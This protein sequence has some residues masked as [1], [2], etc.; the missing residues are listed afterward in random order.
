MGQHAPSGWRTHGPTRVSHCG[1]IELGVA[2]RAQIP[3]GSR[4]AEAEQITETA[5][6]AASGQKFVED[7]IFAHG[8]GETAEAHADPVRV[9]RLCAQGVAVMQEQI[10]I[11]RRRP[12]TR[13][14]AEICAEALPDRLGEH[15]DPFIDEEPAIMC[16]GQAESAQL[17][18]GQ[19]MEGHECGQCSHRG[20]V[21]AKRG[22]HDREIDRQ[23]DV[24]VR[25]T[26]GDPG[27]RVDEDDLAGLED[28]KDLSQRTEVVRS[29][30]S[31]R[32]EGR[33][34]V[35]AGDLSERGVSLFGP[36]AYSRNGV[37]QGVLHAA[38]G[39]GAHPGRAGI[40]AQEDLGAEPE[41]VDH[42]RWQSGDQAFKPWPERRGTVIVEHAGSFEDDE[43]RIGR[44]QQGGEA[45]D[46]SPFNWPARRV[47][48]AAEDAQTLAGTSDRAQTPAVVA[49]VVVE[50]VV[51]E[52]DEHGVGRSCEPRPCSGDKVS[53]HGKEHLLA[54]RDGIVTNG[55]SPGATTPLPTAARFA[56]HI[57][58]GQLLAALLG[59]AEVPG[60]GALT[61]A[62]CIEVAKSARP[63]WSDRYG[64]LAGNAPADTV[65]PPPALA[66]L[67]APTIGARR[68]PGEAVGARADTRSRVL[69]AA[70]AQRG[71]VVVHHRATAPT[72]WWVDGAAWGAC[73]AVVRPRHLDRPLP[74]V[75]A[76][77]GPQRWPG[78]DGSLEERQLERPLP[79][80]KTRGWFDA[81]SKT[82]TPAWWGALLHARHA[83]E[84]QLVPRNDGGEITLIEWDQQVLAP[85]QT[86]DR[87]AVDVHRARATNT[88]GDG[89]VN[90]PPTPAGLAEPAVSAACAP[91]EA[92]ETRVHPPRGEPV[93]A[94]AQSARPVVVGRT[95]LSTWGLTPDPWLAVETEQPATIGLRL[96]AAGLAHGQWAHTGGARS[97]SCPALA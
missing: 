14:M 80:A 50:V 18:R 47:L 8:L 82:C 21:R 55:R 10:R 2:E 39:S 30:R 59:G 74:T 97:G 58:E 19:S 60:S 71:A 36:A 88:V 85:T 96:L 1:W 89:G 51:E 22:T 38:T 87:I 73:I 31:Q 79:R 23:W 84:E 27:G 90:A 44:Q 37:A 93:T 94:G 40:A 65:V 9:D 15:D 53:W 67:T 42:R 56:A 6:V 24:L 72:R 91:G 28:P 64:A 41:L 25:C 16:I 78:H 11:G 33:Q 95:A 66:A 17:G 29:G 49:G 83:G 3:L 69:V 5:D 61:P 77:A 46:L 20:I 13:A 86:T 92:V 63:S 76:Q 35:V 4:N 48:K 62:C 26:D 7:P 57:G 43:Y 52:G 54:V 68:T 70:G 75:P 81:W 34:D 45:H 32:C 12:A